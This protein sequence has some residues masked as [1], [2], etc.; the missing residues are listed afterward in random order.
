MHL[1]RGTGRKL[2]QRLGYIRCLW[3]LAPFELIW[4]KDAQTGKQVEPERRVVP[5][6]HFQVSLHSGRWLI[7][8]SNTAGIYSVS[9]LL[10]RS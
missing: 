6:G 9:N 2:T 5:S 1:T 7:H 4:G 10:L 8:S 3:N